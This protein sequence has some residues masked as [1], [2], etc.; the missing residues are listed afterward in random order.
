MRRRTKSAAPSTSSR[1]SSGGRMPAWLFASLRGYRL[2]WLPR[3][4]VA[5]LML[6]AIAIPGQLATARLAGMPP[7]TGLYAFAAGALA[8]AALGANRYMSVAA[9][10]TIAPIFAGGLSSIAALGTAHYAELATLLAVLVGIT[11][12]AVGLL[13]AGW[14]A[15]LLSIPVTTGFLAGISIHIIV[16]Q[17]PDLLGVGQADGHM[18]VQLVHILDRL[19]EANP[20]TLALGAGVLIVTLVTA[21]ISHRIPGALIGLVGAGLAVAMLHLEARG[22]DVVGALSV[23]PPRLVVP[24]NPGIGEWSQL[25]PLALVV[26]MVCSMQTAAVASA[27]PSDPNQPDDTSRDFLGVGAGSILSGMVGS[28]AVDSSPPSTAIVRDSGGRSQIASLTA[29]AMMIALALLASG[30]MAYLP[31]AALAGILVYIAIKIFRVGEMI[32]IARRG[33]KEI[34]LVAASAALVVVLPIESG[35][36]LA[37]VLSFVHSLYIVARPDCAELARV[38]GSTVWWPP[39]AQDQGEHEDGVMVF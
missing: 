11:L 39:S 25:V 33:G 9:D 31:R 4:L 10:S 15:T 34:L 20:Y 1:R 14:L 16:S 21:A 37:I 22:V 23:P 7:Q 29:V 38:P 13:R 26:A 3:D 24:V 12:A 6:A 5:G 36:L 30:A 17:L 28:F 2:Q 8:F 19:G 18:L 32:N 27:F 35:M